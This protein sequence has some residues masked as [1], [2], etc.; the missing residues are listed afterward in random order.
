[1]MHSADSIMMSKIVDIVASPSGGVIDVIKAIIPKIPC[2]ALLVI[3]KKCI[4]NAGDVYTVIA[5]CIWKIAKYILYEDLVLLECNSVDNLDYYRKKS[6][7]KKEMPI[8]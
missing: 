3:L 2:I 1:M 4:D 6:I 5:S 8:K 7:E